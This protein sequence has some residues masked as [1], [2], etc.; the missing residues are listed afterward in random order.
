MLFHVQDAAFTFS[1]LA[2]FHGKSS[3]LWL[4]D[5]LPIIWSLIF[6]IAYRYYHF[7]K[8]RNELLLEAERQK[9]EDALNYSENLRQGKFSSSEISPD[10]SNQL[11]SSLNEL[12][13]TLML[14]K[15]SQDMRSK[16]DRRL[17]WTSEGLAM[18]GEIL[19]VQT[20][21][22]EDLAYSLISNLVKYLKANQGGF[23][24]TEEDETGKRVIE[25]IACHAYDRKKFAD[26][27][28]SWG[29]GLIGT[30]ALEKKTIYLLEIPDNYL[31]I[32][33]GLGKA[34]PNVL[35]IVPLLVNDEVQGIIEIASFTKFELF[36]IEF[37]EKVADSIAM[38]LSNIKGNLRTATLLKETQAQ[39]EV[40]AL[41]EEKM[42]QNMEEL[43]ATQEQAAR[44]AE[45]FIS[46]TNSVNH[47][48]VRAEYDKEGILLY[49]NTKFL[50]KLGYSGNREVEGR[51]ISLFI[52]EKDREWFNDIWNNLVQGGKHFEG[53][54]KHITKQGQD[55]WTMAT[56]TSIR[57]D[58]GSVEK[59]LFL[60]IDTTEQKKQSLDFEGQIEAINRLNL[61][62]E[63]APD[64]K[65]LFANN[66]FNSTLKYH[67]NELNRL[68]IFDII[69]KKEI[70]SINEVWE[71]VITGKPYQGQMKLFS[72][73]EE[74]K[75]FRVSLSSVNDMY[76]EVSKVVFLAN[77]ITNEKIMESESRKQTQQ[78][79]DQEEKLRLAGIELNRKM[80]EKEAAWQKQSLEFKTEIDLYQDIFYKSDTLM[81]SVDNTGILLFLNKKAEDLWKIKSRNVINKPALDCFRD[82][83]N[84]PFQLNNLIDPSKAK[85]FEQDTIEIPDEKHVLR[86]M[87]MK[88][89]STP[90][91]DRI[92][93]TLYLQ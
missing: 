2:G 8:T 71:G 12:R 34:N 86:K 18:F 55:L 17:N 62:A 82:I 16:E 11:V 49:A 27:K 48:M 85:V 19:R 79:K 37:I 61:K 51:H 63:F 36:Q 76:D 67:E 4:I 83:S 80:A 47:T 65:L 84:F 53:Y 70:E 89:L 44:Q 40:L 7:R 46:F 28:I 14:N 74:E 52:H 43:K 56:Y 87:K 29:E 90:I 25:M 6:F 68:S 21:N 26:R 38:T 3:L 91:N 1:N 23:F 75:W 69:E 39:A 5:L 88:I 58:D 54:M 77:E 20:D 81:L 50:K 57:R 60:A 64:G 93:Y 13:E 35:I 45:K 92:A 42:R 15:I 31:L 22:M 78:L 72:K 73:Y 33:S 10:S 59:I 41:Q 30:C 32:T 66:L 9:I 24:L